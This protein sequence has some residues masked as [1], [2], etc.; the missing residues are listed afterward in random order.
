[1]QQ[2]QTQ[3]KN[4]WISFHNVTVFNNAELLNPPICFPFSGCNIYGMGVGF[5]GLNSIITLSAMA[6]ERYIVITKS[7]CR[8]AV[9]KLRITHHQAQKVTK[10]CINIW[11]LSGPSTSLPFL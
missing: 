1:M 3:L 8:L 11:Y 9:D 7:S 2:I 4:F 10:L 5:F 6:Y